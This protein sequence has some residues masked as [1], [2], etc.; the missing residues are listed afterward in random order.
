MYGFK[1]KKTKEIRHLNAM[2]ELCILDL[3]KKTGE[4]CLWEQLET[5]NMDNV[6][7]NIFEKI[8]HIWSVT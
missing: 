7:D 6:L 4:A 5:L 8:V 2:G 3:K 1:L